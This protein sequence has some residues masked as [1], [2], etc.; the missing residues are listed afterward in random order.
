VGEYLDS[1]NLEHGFYRSAKG[2]IIE[3]AYPGAAQGGAISNTEPP[4]TA[5]SGFW[6]VERGSSHLPK[7]SVSSGSKIRF[8]TKEIHP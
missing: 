5:E 1:S 3:I 8:T 7:H 4:R 2:T 6:G